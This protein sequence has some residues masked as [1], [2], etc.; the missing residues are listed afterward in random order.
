VTPEYYIG[1]AATLPP[2]VMTKA[3]QQATAAFSRLV[4][5]IGLARAREEVAAALEE[6][7][8]PP[9]TAVATFAAVA[10]VLRETASLDGQ[11]GAGR[12]AA[13]FYSPDQPR[14]P[15]GYPAGGQWTD[16]GGDE[17]GRGGMPVYVKDGRILKGHPSLEGK[18]VESLSHRAQLK[19]SREAARAEWGKQARYHGH[20]PEAIHALAAE[21]MAHDRASIEDRTAALRSAR[22]VIESYGGDWRTVSLQAAKGGDHT[23][24]R[25]IDVAADSLASSYPHL[26]PN[27]ETEHNTDRLFEMLAA[28]NPKAMEEDHAYQQALDHLNSV[29]EPRGKGRKGKAKTAADEEPIPFSAD[30]AR[31][32]QPRVPA[33]SPAGWEWTGGGG[34]D[35]F[36]AFRA[37]P[38]APSSLFSPNAD[39]KRPVAGREKTLR[40]LSA[41]QKRDLNAWDMPQPVGLNHASIVHL[42]S[43]LKIES[44]IGDEYD[45]KDRDGKRLG[46]FGTAAAAAKFVEGHG[47]VG[48]G[49]KPVETLRPAKAGSGKLFEFSDP[50][51]GAGRY[52]GPSADFAQVHTHHRHR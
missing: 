10:M 6:M 22:R 39:D 26:F 45:V 9:G 3:K 5:R 29:R 48:G 32:D 2:E 38:P 1:L 40:E 12:L 8:P 41:V 21:M 19:S 20:K 13:E 50:L 44:S 33:G 15:A 37:P 17:Q 30:F 18:P 4:Q 16:V 11:A 31:G 51:A 28:G 7:Q 23:K 42:P 25:G 46:H 35:P 43:G 34:S 49:S 52:A 47:R 36:Q 14:V 27:Q 24:T